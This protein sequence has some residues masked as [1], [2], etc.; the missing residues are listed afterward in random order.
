VDSGAVE[1]VVTFG[2][3]QEARALL[4]GLGADLGDLF[5]LCAGG[6]GAVLLP[7]GDDVLCR[8]GGQKMRKEELLWVYSKAENRREYRLP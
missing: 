2:D 3:P 5:D 1:N 8:G 7:V 6:E 4:E